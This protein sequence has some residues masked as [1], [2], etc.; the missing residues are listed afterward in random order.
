SGLAPG[1]RVLD[2]GTG[3][4]AIALALK[5]ERPDLDVLASDV[6]AD[7]LALARANAQRLGPDVQFTQ[8]DPL[9]GI[10]GPLAA[11][12][13]HPPYV[14]EPERAALAPEILRHEPPAALF[15]GPDGLVVIRRLLDAVASRVGTPGAP[16]LLAL[17]VGAGQA[18]AVAGLLAGAGLVH[19]Q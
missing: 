9:D 14:G 8:A 6:S 7:A 12:P 16:G 2:L 1:A 13:C 3:S 15:A 18:D 17:E 5:H 10:D 4:G 11:V 19:V